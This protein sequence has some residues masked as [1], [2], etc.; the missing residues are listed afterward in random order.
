MPTVRLTGF[1]KDD[2]GHGWSETHDKDG[3][4]S[5]TS[6]T[7][8]LAAFDSLMKTFRR[9]LLGGDAFYIGCRASYKTGSGAVAGDNILLDPP[10]RGP[11]TFSGQDV[12]MDAAEVAVKMRLRND[13][14][15]ARTDVYIRGMWRQVILA[16]TLNF[17]TPAG[18]EW[19]N[20]AN[21]YAA[22]LIS[23]S[24]GWVGT[25]PT[26]TSRGKV[27]GYTSNPDGTVT[28]NV[29]PTNAIAL[30]VAGTKLPVK[31]ARINGSK[32]IL[33]RLLVCTVEAGGAALTTSEKI[34]PSAFETDGTF[35]AIVTGFIPYAA[36]SYFKL[37]QRKTGRPFGVG[38]GRLSA[39]TL[40]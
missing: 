34:S 32:S 18:E 11:Q 30:P 14:S 31:F 10:M 2:D 37:A 7:T 39:A 35:I 5:V 16:G 6:L 27:T 3:G 9:P 13:A 21:A 23:G 25:D 1:F 20:R 12:N 29:T 22:A 15:T 19:K 24:Y 33:N 38:R 36:Q 4:S 8:Y 28:L 40:H 17:T 26:K